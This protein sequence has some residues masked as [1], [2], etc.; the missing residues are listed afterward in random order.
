MITSIKPNLQIRSRPRVLKV[1]TPTSLWGNGEDIIQPG[2]PQDRTRLLAEL[3][4]R[5]GLSWALPLRAE[6]GAATGGANHR[7]PLTLSQKTKALH[8]APKFSVYPHVFII[9]TEESFSKDE[10]LY[11][12]SQPGAGTAFRVD[13]AH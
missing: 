4:D 6:Q 8:H 10:W 12:R 13:E 1:K 3:T 5:L 2:S 11:L 7:A 9:L